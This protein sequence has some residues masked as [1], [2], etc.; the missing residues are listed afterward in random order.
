MTVR[1][2]SVKLLSIACVHS[3]KHTYRTH[4]KNYELPVTLISVK[5]IPWLTKLP[6]TLI[7]INLTPCL[8][9]YYFF[10]YTF[11]KS[12][13]I[14]SYKVTWIYCLGSFLMLLLCPKRSL[15]TILFLLTTDPPKTTFH[16]SWSWHQ[17]NSVRSSLTELSRLISMV[18]I[19][20]NYY[21]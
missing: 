13:G 19:A 2:K 15:V 7:F 20:P 10:P 5:L 3:F 11:Q 18:H 16:C 4:L 1:T 12:T 21:N 6:A 17:L 8:F 9:S 14:N